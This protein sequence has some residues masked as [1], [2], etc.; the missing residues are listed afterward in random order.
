MREH[1][2]FRLFW[3]SAHVVL[4]AAVILLGAGVV[5]EYSTRR[6][7]QGFADAVVPLS[8]N[9]EHKV[10]AILAWMEHGPARRTTNH[11][12]E[13][14]QRDPRITLNYAEL[15]KVCGTA[16]NAFVNLATSS[17]LDARRLLLLSPDGRSKHVVAE[18]LIQGQWAVADPSYHRLFRDAQGKLVTR[19]QMKAP[20]IWRQATGVVPN[21]P[22]IYTYER[23]VHVRLSRIPV[24]G[25]YLRPML[26]R[27]VP[28]WEEAFDW[29]LLVE[30]ES[31][32]FTF[33]AASLVLLALVVRTA[34][35]WYGRRRLRIDRVRLRDQLRQA[36]K[37]LLQ[38]S[39]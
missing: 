33:L 36:G 14:A 20:E 37:V 24:V 7:L 29:T 35:S 18:V 38:Q 32:A 11:A 25:K 28:G 17:G 15:L 9:A 39:R 16:T 23:T 3:V 34:L 10:E 21:Y 2:Y 5:W 6:Y 19:E 4:A 13:L 1:P 8:D 12:G 26:N 22:E 31:L 30:R 27:I